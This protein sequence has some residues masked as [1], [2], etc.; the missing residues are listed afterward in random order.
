MKKSL[1]LACSF[2]LLRHATAQQPQPQG[3]LKELLAGPSSPDQHA[4]WLAGMKEWRAAE[5]DNLHYDPSAYENKAFAWVQR[6]FIYAQMMA[7]DRYFYDPAA[8]RYTVDRYLDDLKKRYGGID[9]VLIWPTYP[10]I[11]IDNRNQYDL[12]ADMPGGKTAVRQMI[13]DFRKR[14]VRVFFPIMYWDHGT[15]KIGLS[16]PVA[17]IREMKDLG[18]DGMNGDTMHGIPEAFRHAWDSLG[19]P[20]AFQ[21]ELNLQELKMISWNQ[22][23]WGYYWP[24]TYTPGVS[25]YKWFEPRHQINVTNRWATDKTDDLQYAFF[26]GVGYNAWENIWGIWNQVPDRYAE[27]IRRIGMLYRAFPGIWS[28]ADWEPHIPVLQKGIF[29]SAFP[30]GDRTVYTLVNRDSLSRQGGQLQLPYEKDRLYFD[31]WNGTSLTPQRKDDRIVLSF[32]VEGHGFGAVLSIRTGGADAALNRLLTAIHARAQQPLHRLP[33]TWKPLPQQ[34]VKMKKTAA[35]AGTPEGMIRI[36]AAQQYRFSSKG[37]MIEGNEL[38]E[39]VGIQHPWETHPA[40]SQTH[41]LSVPS[42]YIDK[43]P[44]T[45]KQFKAFMNATGYHPADDHNF[46]KDW[47]NG[48]YPAGWADK[49]VTWV[50]LDDARAYA[51]WAGK[52]LPHEWEWQYAAQGTDNRRYPWGNVKDTTRIPPPAHGRD[53]RPPTA[54]DAYPAGAS[55]FGVMD[56]T[57]NVW[58]WT[59]EYTDEHT[60]AAVLKGGGYYR[61]AGSNWYFP[62]AS[63]LSQYGKYLLMAPSIDR[64][65]CIGFRCVM[66]E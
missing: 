35:P 60:R 7:H 2:F 59:D 11:G 16:M 55:P 58:Q 50:S 38:P 36:P 26:N 32:P 43:Y 25:L 9:A 34:I 17:L 22:L 44:V 3:D 14:G 46:L 61:S 20:V 66:D 15:R 30:A 52:R 28:S 24:Y 1:L 6:T 47:K 8:R 19:Y 42:F 48:T 65:G 39:A 49:P 54:V 12:V 57:G 56:M 64:S 10:N 63:A 62:T 51:A 45:N 53:M 40:R 4:A 13:R 18:A 33:D 41:T 37:I 21:P 31:L 29:A 27:A 5:K 23:S